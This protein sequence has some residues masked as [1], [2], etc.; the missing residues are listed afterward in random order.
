LRLPPG[1]GRP[2]RRAGLQRARTRGGAARRA[3]TLAHANARQR[4]TPAR[5]QPQGADTHA[6][7]CPLVPLSLQRSW[8]VAPAAPPVL[9]ACLPPV[10]ASALCPLLPAPARVDGCVLPALVAQEEARL[11]VLAS[12]E[13]RAAAAAHA[14]ARNAAEAAARA[15]AAR[16]IAAAEAG[17]GAWMALA[18]TPTAATWRAT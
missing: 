4:V 2:P 12:A 18:P 5:Q 6:P 3:V 15:A 10:H 11:A 7:H 13:H 8:S 1:R 14:A 9:R 16:R 17:S